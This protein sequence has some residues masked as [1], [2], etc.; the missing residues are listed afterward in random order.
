MI[1]SPSDKSVE[2]TRRESRL[3]F[4]FSTIDTLRTAEESEAVRDTCEQ[5][6]IDFP[7]NPE[8]MSQLGFS[9]LRL[10]EYEECISVYERCVQMNYEISQSLYSIGCAYHHL[11]D[12]DRTLASFKEAIRR[13]PRHF[14]SMAGIATIA[15]GRGE[16]SEA[17]KWSRR[18]LKYNPAFLTPLSVLIV[19]ALIEK[20]HESIPLLIERL[21]TIGVITFGE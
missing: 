8:L 20:D 4:Y 15:L 5:A 21:K 7:D 6:L 9:L 10:E 16:F 13:N 18:A 14:H 12:Y 17:A 11:G 3:S 19:I 1:S 2:P